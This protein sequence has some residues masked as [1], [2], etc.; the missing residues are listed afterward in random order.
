MIKAKAINSFNPV[1]IFALTVVL[2][3]SYYIASHRVFVPTSPAP[4]TFDEMSPII[5]TPTLK[6]QPVVREVVK[7]ASVS[8]A[9]LPQTVSPMPILPPVVTFKVLPV[10]PSSA[11]ADSLSG[12]VLLS[13]FVG[14]AGQPEKIE[15]KV[16]SGVAD[17]DQAATAAVSQW[18]FSPAMQGGTA[19]ASC[20]EV[21]VRFEVK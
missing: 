3:A 21:P 1:A 9:P 7:P 10:Y 18:R 5:V 20:F 8:I 6:A 4:I 12:T 19:L 2:A 14:P 15:T 13:V 11:L 16:S 17:F